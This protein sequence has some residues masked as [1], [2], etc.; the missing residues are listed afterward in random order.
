MLRCCAAV[1]TVLAIGY[2]N[3]HPAQRRPPQPLRPLLTGQSTRTRTRCRS[4][5]PRVRRP[6][7]M[8]WLRRGRQGTPQQRWPPAPDLS[9][10]N[11]LLQAV[12]PCPKGPLPTRTAHSVLPPRPPAAGRLKG[13]S[14]AQ[15]SPLCLALP[16]KHHLC[17]RPPRAPWRQSRRVDHAPRRPLTPRHPAAACCCAMAAAPAACAAGCA[18]CWPP[19]PPSP[20]ACALHCCSP[21]KQPLQGPTRAAPA[22]APG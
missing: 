12:L 22:Q 8:H 19:R 20:P 6:G 4:S 21:A 16:Q 14:Q 18:G 7:L 3:C 17:P 10:L 15:T 1:A 5:G 2:G 13:H 9:A 11:V